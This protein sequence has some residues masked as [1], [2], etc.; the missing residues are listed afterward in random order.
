[1]VVT[2][3]MSSGVA[4]LANLSIVGK[5]KMNQ[6]NTSTMDIAKNVLTSNSKKS[7]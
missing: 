6:Q 2:A 7:I 3:T 5:M 4:K 1:V